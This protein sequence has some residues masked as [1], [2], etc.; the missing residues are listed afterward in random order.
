MKGGTKIKMET[1]KLKEILNNLTLLKWVRK[2]SADNLLEDNKLAKEKFKIDSEANSISIMDTT[3]TK[4]FIT[5]AKF[6]GEE[7]VRFDLGQMANLIEIVGTKG[8]LIIPK[9]SLLK[10]MI[11]EVKDDVVVICPLPRQDKVKEKK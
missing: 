8:E 9:D 6:G 4:L 11:A 2:F 10:E 3:A 1:N 7:L 5:K